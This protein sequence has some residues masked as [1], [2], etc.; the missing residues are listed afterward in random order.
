MKVSCKLFE[1][2]TECKSHL[3]VTHHQ[4]LMII[5][6]LRTHPPSKTQLFKHLLILVDINI[7]VFPIDAYMLVTINT[8]LPISFIT[9]DGFPPSEYSW[10]TDF[11]IIKYE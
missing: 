1:I 7:A 6:R 5:T 3:N 8:P 9:I 2:R 4:V 11:C 10:P